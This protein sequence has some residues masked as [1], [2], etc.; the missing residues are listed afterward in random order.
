MVCNCRVNANAGVLYFLFI[1]LIFIIGREKQCIRSQ[2]PESLFQKDAGRKNLVRHVTSDGGEILKANLEP[3]AEEATQRWV[4]IFKKPNKP[5]ICSQVAGGGGG[6]LIFAIYNRIKMWFMSVIKRHKAGRN[7]RKQTKVPYW[8]TR[9]FTGDSKS[10]VTAV[11]VNL[12]PAHR[13][14][15]ANARQ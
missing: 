9:S 4:E 6:R 15:A 1:F 11:C 13:A 5:R 10:G 14:A 3:K 12:G 2:T 7:C 8:V